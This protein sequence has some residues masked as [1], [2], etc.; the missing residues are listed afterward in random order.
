MIEAIEKAMIG[1]NN[2]PVFG[3]VVHANY[4]TTL[5]YKDL[6]DSENYTRSCSRNVSESEPEASVKNRCKAVRREFLHYV[7]NLD[8]T[9]LNETYKKFYPGELKEMDR[10]VMNEE[11]NLAK[12]TAFIDMFKEKVNITVTEEID[13]L[14]SMMS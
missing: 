4:S 12:L 1:S 7:K 11:G 13:R 3:I 8:R 2:K 5:Q 9:I 6:K 10:I 14:K